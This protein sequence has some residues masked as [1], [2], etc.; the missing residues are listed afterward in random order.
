MRWLRIKPL[1]VLFFR[2]PGPFSAG[3]VF[4]AETE[5][6]PGILPF[7]GAIR[8]EAARALGLSP[9]VLR[10]GHESLG[11]PDS[12]GRLKFCG[13]FLAKDGRVFFPAPKAA[14]YHEGL[15]KMVFSYPEEPEGACLSLPDGF[16]I[17]Q[18]PKGYSPPAEEFFLGE[19]SYFDLF[20]NA[21]TFTSEEDRAFVS[22][23]FEI[24]RRVGIALEKG[25]R[26]V[27]EGHLYTQSVVRLKDG[28][29][30][31]VGVSG[32]PSEFPEKGVLTLGGEG[33]LA[34]Y[35]TMDS[36]PLPFANR[37]EA[38]G[39]ARMAFVVLATLGVFK[40]G[41]LPALPLSALK[42]RLVGAV[43]PKAKVLGG[44][45]I[46]R[47]RPRPLV[48]TVSAGAVYALLFEDALTKEQEEKIFE[49]FWARPLADDFSF[50]PYGQAG[51]GLSFVCL[52]KFQ[53][54]V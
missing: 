19:E 1:D 38:K 15:G 9:A 51:F 10:K 53:G 39:G 16:G 34:L 35:E 14:A 41:P 21:E 33:K 47:N 4:V 50:Y 29:S 24:E 48:K 28:V 30:F 40:S 52:S 17:W 54:G 6:V 32:L 31:V 8:A 49:N 12:L 25:S 27:R 46:S 36:P 22:D 11:G 37:P 26:R 45:D 7:I 42:A 18:L 2:R 23:F 20:K 3:G 13:P 44:F 43:V 5:I